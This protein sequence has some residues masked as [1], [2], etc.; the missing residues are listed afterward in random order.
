[1]KVPLASFEPRRDRTSTDRRFVPKP[2]RHASSRQFESQPAETPGR[3]E[4]TLNTRQILHHADL[5]LTAARPAASPTSGRDGSLDVR[6]ATRPHELPGD[7]EPVSPTATRV[8]NIVG[9][10]RLARAVSPSVGLAFTSR[11]R[12]GPAWGLERHARGNH[13]ARTHGRGSSRGFSSCAHASTGHGW[14]PWLTRASAS[15]SR[16]W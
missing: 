10:G 4:S 13:E 5:S 8:T 2:T 9:L 12:A 7:L 6:V 1:M 16:T 11:C 3:Y 15:S 14:Q